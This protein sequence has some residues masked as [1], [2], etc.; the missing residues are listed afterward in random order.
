MVHKYIHYLTSHICFDLVG[1]L[2]VNHFIKQEDLEKCLI[3]IKEIGKN[4]KK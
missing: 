3:T 2:H 4:Y 1:H